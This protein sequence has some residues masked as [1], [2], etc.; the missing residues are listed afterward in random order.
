MLERSS[1]A[2]ASSIRAAKH[3]DVLVVS[4]ASSVPALSAAVVDQLAPCFARIDSIEHSI[5][6]GARPPGHATMIG[7]LACAGTPFTQWQDG[8][9][10]GVHGWHDLTPRRYPAPVG[11]RLLANCDVP[12]LELFPSR[13]A[14]VR[15]TVFRAGV[16]QHSHMLAI[17]LAAWAVRLKLIRSL[18]AHVPRLHRVALARA[19]NGSRYSA[20]QVTVRGHDH[21]SRPIARTWALVAGSDH[22]PR[23]PTFPAIALAR[24]LMRRAISLRGAA[25]CIGLLTVDEILHEGRELDIRT[26]TKCR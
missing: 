23:I 9:W 18:A 16:A 20:M 22:G 7:V 26:A 2:S 5:T 3:N 12:D 1:A 19:R 6:S 17:V 24:K 11:W 21:E 13:Y 8:A 10:R 4:G 25:P 14:G 15:T